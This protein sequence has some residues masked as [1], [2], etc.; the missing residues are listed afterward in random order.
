L[1]SNLST[2]C[3]IFI[4]RRNEAS[5]NSKQHSLSPSL[6]G[7]DVNWTE[8]ELLVEELE[9]QWYALRLRLGEDAYKDTFSIPYE[10]FAKGMQKLETGRIHEGLGEAVA[11]R[12]EAEELNETDSV[13]ALTSAKTSYDATARG[14]SRLAG[15]LVLDAVIAA[16]RGELKEEWIVQVLSGHAGNEDIQLECLREI[17]ALWTEGIW[18]WSA[19]TEPL[20]SPSSLDSQ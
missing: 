11:A 7:G 8:A 17:V 16:A 10:R 2:L 15:L 13:V 3:K 14:L 19:G 20:K 4:P 12:F 6:E 18:P 1:E 9:R 5:N